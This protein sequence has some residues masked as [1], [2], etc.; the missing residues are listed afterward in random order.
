[1][2]V[3]DSVYHRIGTNVYGDNIQMLETVPTRQEKDVK[4][5]ALDEEMAKVLGWYM[6]DGYLNSGEMK[7]WGLCF[8]G[9]ESYVHE[10][11]KNIMISRGY[12]P[13]EH[14]QG[15][16][17]MTSWRIH[18]ASLTRAIERE[19]GHSAKGKRVSNLILQSP[20]QIQV[21]FLKYWFSADG[22]CSNQGTYNSRVRL[23]SI[24]RDALQDAQ[25]MLFNMGI[26]CR[27]GGNKVNL[28]EKE[29]YAY[30]LKLKVTLPVIS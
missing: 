23:T 2:K 19:F 5:I 4:L 14:D 18:N 30:T 10:E 7:T 26:L 29:F 15:E 3:G 8:G 25:A 21:Q 22:T 28:G 12:A 1:M 17:N 9:N 13:K 24:N 27:I 20:K 11:L 6:G 16:K